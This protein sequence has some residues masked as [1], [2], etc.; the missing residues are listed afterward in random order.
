MRVGR[1]TT[2]A[3]LPHVGLDVNALKKTY[4]AVNDMVD[5]RACCDTG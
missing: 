1:K 5:D 4:G 3:G 2:A